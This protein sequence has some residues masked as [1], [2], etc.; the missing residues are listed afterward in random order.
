MAASQNTLGLTPEG[1]QR[2]IAELAMTLGWQTLAE[3]IAKK[4][5]SASTQL[6]GGTKLSL[7]EVRLLQGEIR[8]HS[9]LVSYVN[10]CVQKTRAKGE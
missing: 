3:H 5:D 4:I 10:T 9:E 8:A 6:T 1:K 2:M 7:E